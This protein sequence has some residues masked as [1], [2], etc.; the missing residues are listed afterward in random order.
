MNSPWLVILKFFYRISA[1]ADRRAHRHRLWPLRGTSDGHGSNRRTAG[2]RVVYKTLFIL[3]YI[4]Y[5]INLTDNNTQRLYPT[6]ISSAELSSLVNCGH[7]GGRQGWL[8]L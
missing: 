5:Y 7:R 2:K 1:D 8:P 6:G 3:V 4:K